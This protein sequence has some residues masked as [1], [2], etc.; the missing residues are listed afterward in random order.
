MQIWVSSTRAWSIKYKLFSSV[1]HRLYV[2]CI[3]GR[4]RTEHM[5]TLFPFFKNHRGAGGAGGDG[6][7]GVLLIYGPLLPAYWDSGWRKQADMKAGEVESRATV[8]W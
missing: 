4:L 7:A 8:S 3:N 2:C 5:K 6:G 1:L